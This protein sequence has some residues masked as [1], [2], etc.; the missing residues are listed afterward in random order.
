MRGLTDRVHAS[1]RAYVG[2]CRA[3]LGLC[4]VNTVSIQCLCRVYKE[5]QRRDS[6]GYALKLVQFK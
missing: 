4:R 5:V 2:S 3:M 6:L 1:C